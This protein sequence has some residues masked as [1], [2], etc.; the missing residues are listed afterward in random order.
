MKKSLLTLLFLAGILM[1][2]LAQNFD[3][4]INGL[5]AGSAFPTGLSVEALDYSIFRLDSAMK[6]KPT[7]VIVYKADWSA[8]DVEQMTEYSSYYKMLTV[9][10]GYQVFGITTQPV[11]TMKE[12]KKVQK[13]KMPLFKADEGFLVKLGVSQSGIAIPSIF[14]VDKDGVIRYV[15]T[16]PDVKTRPLAD[17]VIAKAKEINVAYNKK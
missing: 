12:T 8:S 3:K 4:T 6:G 16:N 9:G 11:E 10:E 7:I 1:N 5:K 13:W 17:D 15:Y 2:A 14:I